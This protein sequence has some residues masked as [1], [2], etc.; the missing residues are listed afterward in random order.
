MQRSE[1]SL[2]YKLHTN[3]KPPWNINYKL[4]KS[5]TAPDTHLYL[6]NQNQSVKT[7]HGET[8]VKRCNKILLGKWKNPVVRHLAVQQRRGISDQ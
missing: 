2:E 3:R 1:I 4:A 6:N 5:F 8:T 7:T